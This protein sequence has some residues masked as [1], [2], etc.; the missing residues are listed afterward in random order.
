MNASEKFGITTLGFVSVYA[1]DHAQA[2]AFYSSVF[3]P[4]EQV[5]AGIVG[6]K[7]GDTWLTLLESRMG[8]QPDS[9]PRNIEFA[10]VVD[11]AS[12]VDDL[13]H[14]LVAA[15]A[16][17]LTHPEDGEMYVPMRFA[18]VDDPFGVRID[19]VHPTAH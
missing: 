9:N 10:I 17:P 5:M 4:A 6:W 16:S 3:G 11:E 15:G 7:L 12:K 1:R 19:I 8:T 14:D 18:A 13:F 2:E